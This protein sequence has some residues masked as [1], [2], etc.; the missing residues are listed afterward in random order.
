MVGIGALIALGAIQNNRA[1]DILARSQEIL[2]KATTVVG[3]FTQQIGKGVGKADFHLKKGRKVA[4]FSDSVTDLQNE[5]FRTT[6]NPKDGTYRVQDV[7]VYNM[8]YVPGFEAFTKIQDPRIE[9]KPKEDPSK[10]G[11]G[12]EPKTDEPKEISL[13]EKFGL[14]AKNSNGDAEPRDVRMSRMDGKAVASYILG[15]STV[16]LDAATAL[17]VGADFTGEN[18]QTVRMRFSDVRLDVN[19]EDSMFTYMPDGEVKEQ[20]KIETG[21]LKVGDRIPSAFDNEALKMLDKYMAGKKNSVIVFF[22]DKNA[23]DGD[24]L[25]KF[26]AIAKRRIP[27]DV[28]VIGVALTANWQKLFKGKPKFPLII[29]APLPSDAMATKFGVVYRPTIYVVDENRTVKYVQIGSDTRDLDPV[30]KSIGIKN[31]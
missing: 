27:N 6:V 28:A 2:G 4:V 25:A 17:P 16:Y 14:D 5:F 30:L 21:M 22:D 3:T 7:R 15:G 13:F 8:L 31:P 12:S 18:G 29:D 20:K 9:D 23:A 1:N 19:L 10:S 24:V 11:K 26:D